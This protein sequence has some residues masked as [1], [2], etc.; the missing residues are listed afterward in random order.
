M[1]LKVSRPKPEGYPKELKTIGDRIR[2]WRLDNQLRQADI[3]KIL[4]VCGDS[5]T[6]W[7]SQGRKPALK[8]MPGI[9]KMIGYLPVKI[10]TS[11][12]GEKIL[13]E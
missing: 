5:V 8:Q 11:T 10:D 13:Y 4:G 6:G 12:F 9:I 2:A 3:A 7:E 1:T